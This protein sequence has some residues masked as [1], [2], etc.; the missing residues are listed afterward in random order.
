MI[1]LTLPDRMYDNDLIMAQR[2]HRTHADRL[3]YTVTVTVTVTYRSY[4][5]L[6]FCA[7]YY[8]YILLYSFVII[9][10]F[11]FVFR[12]SCFVCVSNF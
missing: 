12:V 10:V 2:S 3:Q 7:V 1:T 5:F 4:F 6:F 11:V 8:C 9:C